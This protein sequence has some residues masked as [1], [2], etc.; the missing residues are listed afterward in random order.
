MGIF[1]F[2]LCIFS[3]LFSFNRILRTL[4]IPILWTCLVLLFSF[5]PLG[6]AWVNFAFFWPMMA[7]LIWYVKGIGITFLIILSNSLIAEYFFEKNKKILFAL[8]I[9]FLIVVLC[10]FYS[11]YGQAHGKEI[12]VALI[13][14]NIDQPWVFRVSDLDYVIGTYENLTLSMSDE[15]PDLVI[16]PEYSIPTDLTQ[17]KVHYERIYNLSKKMNSYIIL[18]TTT[19][20]PE[21]FNDK[22]FLIKK[23]TDSMVIFS[24]HGEIVGRYDTPLPMP[25]DKMVIKGENPYTYNIINTEI[26]NFTIGICFEEMILERFRKKSDFII[27]LVNDQIFDDTPGT[28]LISLFPSLIAAENKKYL[29]RST[30]T[31]VTE[32]ISPYGKVI[33]KL[34]SFKE[35]TLIGKIYI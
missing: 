4:I 28:E 34:E 13:Q 6:S 33:Y 17:D 2:F 7:P 5:N 25:F 31:G 27:T 15:K 23:K 21:A 1:G 32:I 30:N 18:G 29:L 24:P 22:K 35:G 10:F 9:L 11:Y 12:K 8:G 14:G 16:W 26:A 19:M 3:K 20:T